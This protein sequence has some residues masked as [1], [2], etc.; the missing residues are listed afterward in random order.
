MVGLFSFLFWFWFCFFFAGER[1][2]DFRARFD[3]GGGN[4][5]CTEGGC[6]RGRCGGGEEECV[7]VCVCVYGV[8]C[9]FFGR[10]VV[11]VVVVDFVV[12]SCC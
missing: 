10:G 6:V 3:F 5:C 9:I 11:V 7:C 2:G 4:Y 12:H 8:Y 1:G